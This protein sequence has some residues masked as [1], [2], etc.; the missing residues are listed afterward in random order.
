MCALGTSK[1]QWPGESSEK[2][3]KGFPMFFTLENFKTAFL[4]DTKLW[5]SRHYHHCYRHY[6]RVIVVANLKSKR[7]KVKC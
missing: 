3:F 1:V 6:R 2:K 5:L 7:K 4:G